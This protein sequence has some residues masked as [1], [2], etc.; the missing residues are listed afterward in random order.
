VKSHLTG[1]VAA[2]VCLGLLPVPRAHAALT[3]E[4]LRAFVKR[5]GGRVDSAKDNLFVTSKAVGRGRVEIR[6]LNDGEK[7][8]LG[9]Y[10][11]GFGNVSGAKDAKALYEYLLH[12]NSDLAIGS[13]FVDKDEDIGYKFFLSTREALAYA[14]F[15]TVYLAMTNVIQERGPVI[16]RMAGGAGG[17]NDARTD[18]AGGSSAGAVEAGETT[19]VTDAAARP[20][21]MGRP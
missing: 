10:A 1:F 20:R 19:S 14:T 16:A 2:I 5:A 8:R 13:F 3:A 7:Q 9:F 18:P 6:L 4:S 21:R 11:Y 15:E 12:A 17:S